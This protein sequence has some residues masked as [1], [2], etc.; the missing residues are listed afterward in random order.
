MTLRTAIGE[1]EALRRT[2]NFEA[3]RRCL[4]A[5][6][7]EARTARRDAAATAT[8]EETFLAE[9]IA[10]LALMSGEASLADIFLDAAAAERNSTGEWWRGDFATLQRIH[11]ALAANAIDAARELFREARGLGPLSAVPN[12][13]IELARWESSRPWPQN[14]D[15]WRERLFTSAYLEMARLAIATG[16]CE[17]ALRMSGRGLRFATADG[18]PPL[19]R[20][21]RIPL[22]IVTAEVRVV[23]GHA[24]DAREQL[25]EVGPIDATRFPAWRA[26]WL[27]LATRA[28]WLEGDLGRALELA[29]EHLR[30][31]ELLRLDHA[32]AHARLNIVELRMQLNE[33]AAARQL[34][35]AVSG[36][37]APVRW[38]EIAERLSSLTIMCAGQRTIYFDGPRSVLE[39]KEGRPQ[40]SGEGAKWPALN[41]SASKRRRNWSL[42]HAETVDGLMAELRA[43]PDFVGQISKELEN[44]A[45]EGDSPLITARIAFGR[46]VHAY[47]GGRF[48]E[49]VSWLSKARQDLRFLG[50]PA[51]LYECQRWLVWSWRR[52]GQ[53]ESEWHAL[54]R[55]NAA[56]LDRIAATLKIEDRAAFFLNK[57][58]EEEEDLA[59]EL[60]VI[61]TERRSLAGRIAP[62]RRLRLMARCSRLIDRLL[63]LR[64]AFA[65]TVVAGEKRVEEPVRSTPLWRRLL[66]PPRQATLV[67]LVLPNAVAVFTMICGRLTVN[68][69]PDTSRQTIREMVAQCHADWS[70]GSAG[71]LAKM[72][73]I[74]A[75]LE[76]LPRWITRLE[77]LGD[78]VLHG[79]PFAALPFQDREL[80]YR[81]AITIA[82][83]LVQPPARPRVAKPRAVFAGIS[84]GQEGQPL[85]DNAPQLRIVRDA[86][87]PNILRE[88]DDTSCSVSALAAA[89]ATANV[90]HI[91]CHGIFDPESPH[92]TGL[93]LADGML[94]LRDLSRSYFASLQLAMLVSCWSADAYVRPGRWVVSAP[95]VLCRAGAE[96]VIAA[97]WEVDNERVA[98]FLAK[99]YENL[100]T[101]RRDEALRR[102]QIDAADSLLPYVW[103]SFQLHGRRERLHWKGFR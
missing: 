41:R 14:S 7:S 43:S 56:L 12:S 99:L 27:V 101:M 25:A 87:A 35:D 80:I 32:V 46:G 81:F 97:L 40:L 39:Q 47:A 51:E 19:V 91:T 62:L 31:C 63:A 5:A 65:R 73:G 29:A 75:A 92:Q 48:E 37:A 86:V 93:L 45:A 88:L 100:K 15:G 24:T 10:S 76:D 58:S 36:S 8:S 71:I 30:F 50:I 20:E 18:A 85:L 67:F 83:S 60:K 89:M 103:A 23:Q 11:I 82:H 57:W 53:G 28:A 55:E 77:I 98:P 38:P 70:A 95:E 94:T 21:S 79:V 6:L 17:K 52:M 69:L 102:A 54:R 90:V 13:D 61:D 2:G 33:H 22:Q 9:N 74:E 66:V 49:A 44:V 3:A 1:A 4:E 16:E 26:Q 59:E 34:L 84:R 78:D 96:S 42:S 64:D 68:I 72:I